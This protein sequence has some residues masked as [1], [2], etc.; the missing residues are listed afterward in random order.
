MTASPHS[1]STSAQFGACF[2][3]SRDVK[4]STLRA[5]LAEQLDQR[6]ATVSLFR[7]FEHE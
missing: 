1:C 2:S 4:A 6:C 3:R 7:S 5:A